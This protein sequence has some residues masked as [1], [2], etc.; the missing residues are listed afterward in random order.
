ME[1]VQIEDLLGRKLIEFSNEAIQK[2]ITGKVVMITGA[3]GSI[4]SEISKQLMAF[5]YKKLIM[6]DQAETALFELQQSTEKKCNE[7]CFFVLG[8]IRNEERIKFLLNEFKPDI[9]FHAAAYKHVPLMEENPYEAVKTNIKGTKIVADLSAKLGVKKFVMISTDKAVN[10]TSVMGATKRIAELYITALNRRSNCKFIVTRFG[11]V[12]ES[13]GSV[14]PV[15]KRQIEKGGPLTVT[16]PEITRYFM[17]IP[18]ACHLLLEAETMGK[19]GEVFVFDMGH[20]VKILDLAKKIIQLNGLNYPKDIDIKIT[21]LRPGEK[22]HEELLTANENRISTY[23]PKITIA[24]IQDYS[25]N[26]EEAILELTA[27]ECEENLLETQ[28]KLVHK[29]K[30]IVPEFI[31]NN[32]IYSSIDKGEVTF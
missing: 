16:H 23:H 22:I 19:G 30:Q 14:I 29:M 1:K 21:G 18:E 10:P 13:S 5:S 31:S 3:A 6:M 17:T 25:P 8:D 24:E 4:G 12:L 28:M 27:Y 7:N 9:I 20:P 15:F 32:S 2:E 26:L 11:N